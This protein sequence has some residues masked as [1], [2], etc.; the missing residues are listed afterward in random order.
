[1][2][3]VGEIKAF[4]KQIYQR[5]YVEAKAGMELMSE[6]DKTKIDSYANEINEFTN[7]EGCWGLIR[8]YAEFADK[9]LIRTKNLAEP[10][11]LETVK[12]MKKF[13]KLGKKARVRAEVDIEEVIQKNNY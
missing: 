13:T 9:G 12:N 11:F 1:M 2:Q 3:V 5:E 8:M 4:N 10:R 7:L 6:R